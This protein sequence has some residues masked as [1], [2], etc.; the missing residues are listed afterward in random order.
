MLF[1]NVYLAAQPP[2]EALTTVV[3]AKWEVIHV[4]LDVFF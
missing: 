4:G 2:F 1:I 3:A